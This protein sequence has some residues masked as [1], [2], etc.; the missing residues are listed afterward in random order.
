MIEKLAVMFAVAKDYNISIFAYP[1]GVLKAF[2]KCK[3][4]FQD[5]I[6]Y[7]WY[8]IKYDKKNGSDEVH[9]LRN[10]SY[11]IPVPSSSKGHSPQPHRKNVYLRQALPLNNSDTDSSETSGFPPSSNSAYQIIFAAAIQDL[12]DV[13]E[14]LIK[15]EVT[16]KAAT[17]AGCVRGGFWST[18]LAAATP[19]YQNGKK[20]EI[21]DNGKQPDNTINSSS[22]R[23]SPPTKITGSNQDRTYNNAVWEAAPS[24]ETLRTRT[25]S[26][27]KL[28][29]QTSLVAPT[30]KIWK[31]TPVN[32]NTLAAHTSSS[33][34][35]PSGM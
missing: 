10:S 13:T 15:K 11:P 3:E 33:T 29:T 5:E 30:I 35:T 21:I 25:I 23:P 14:D 18:M 34:L 32:T 1:K 19:V 7:N 20:T 31:E 2:T 28:P 17:I 27:N 22:K 9:G 26:E 16:P 12:D 4:L 6:P 24:K 8:P